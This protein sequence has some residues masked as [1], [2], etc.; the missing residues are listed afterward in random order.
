MYADIVE[1]ACLSRL[2]ALN[3]SSHDLKCQMDQEVQKQDVNFGRVPLALVFSYNVQ[4]LKP[5]HTQSGMRG[6]LCRS[7]RCKMSYL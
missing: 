6:L 1:V 7:L 2:Q 3:A 5:N 4:D